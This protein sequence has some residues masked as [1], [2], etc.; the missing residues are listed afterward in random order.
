MAGTREMKQP[1]GKKTGAIVAGVTLTAVVGLYVGLCAWVGHS[2]HIMPNVS[3]AGVDV[4]GMTVDQARSALEK[5]IADRGNEIAVSLVCQGWEGQISAA[6]LGTD[7]GMMAQTAYAQGRGSFLTNGFH[8]LAHM[9]G[10]ESSVMLPRSGSEPVLD[11]RLAEAERAVAE[12]M[13]HPGWEISGE[14][15]IIH[16]GTTGMMLETE[17]VYPAV[18]DA[19][20]QAF[21]SDEKPAAV[22]IPVVKDGSLNFDALYAQVHVEPQDA[23]MDPETHKISDHVVGVS[24]DRA[25]AQTAYDRAGDGETIQVP[26]Q[27]TQPKETRESLEAKLY[28]NLLGEATSRVGGSANRKH[29][30]KLS[31]EAC[32]NIILLPGDV[33][34]Y[35][36]VTGSR[37]AGKGYLS[38]PVYSGGASVDEVGGGICQTSST[39]YY[40]VLHTTL[41][42]VERHSHMYAVGYVPDGMDATVYY[43]ASDFKFRN[44]TKYPMKIVTQSYDKGGE[45]FLTVKL[46]GTSENGR[47]AVPERTRFDYVEPTVKYVADPAVPRGTYRV[48]RKQNPYT[49]RSAQTYRYIYEKDGTL[50]EK[51]NMG[52]SRYKMRPETRFYNPQDGDPATWPNGV[53]PVAPLPTPPAPP[54]PPVVPD[55]PP[56]VPDLPPVTPDLPPVIPNQPTVKPDLPPVVPEIP[57]TDQSGSLD[58]QQPPD[59]YGLRDPA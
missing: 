20:D 39:L 2:E 23:V 43:G 6:E 47:Y 54:T 17:S 31:A 12:Q 58:D 18:M 53:P 25:A 3:V 59:G 38:A 57:P 4:S 5:M 45:R 10:Q 16:K 49:G 44:N 29:N 11:S 22:E 37:S 36:G 26:L 13:A 30:V 51:Q 33:F 41:E 40:A 55:L 50:V 15:L 28:K 1:H 9:L 35:N 42:V 27:M 21:Q 24:F 7:W 19:F 8:Q 52:V 46:Y 34:S 56:V 48:D 32:N 14:N